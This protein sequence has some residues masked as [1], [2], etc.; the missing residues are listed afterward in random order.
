M[1]RTAAVG[2]SGGVDS[3]VAAHLLK[4]QGYEVLGL[5]MLTWDGSLPLKDEGRSG[6]YGPGE[7]RDLES[8][9]AVARSL[10]IS[11]HCVSLAKEFHSCVLDYVRQ[12][13]RQGRT[14]NP[15]ARCN[16][17]LKFGLLLDKAR[18][19]GLKFDFF[20]TGHYA[21]LERR[22]GRILLKRAADRR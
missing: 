2:L 14:P 4:S 8:A 20:A 18:R 17:N 22:D 10:G 15:C 5:T 7:A 16:Q 6:C 3:A 9:R 13:Y 1:N 12:E 19:Q 11:H 21:K